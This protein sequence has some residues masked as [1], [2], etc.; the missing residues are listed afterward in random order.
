VWPQLVLPVGYA[1]L[2]LAYL[3]EILRRLLG[4]EPRRDRDDLV[5]GGLD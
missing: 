5:K 2:V 4:L 1:M 3:E